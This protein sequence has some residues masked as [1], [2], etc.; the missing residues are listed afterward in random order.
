MFGLTLVVIGGRLIVYQYLLST[1][2]H[3]VAGEII[4]TGTVYRTS[5]GNVD[6]IR[7]RFTDSS[8]VTRSGLSSGYSG[9]VGETV[10]LEYALNF[11]FVHRISGEGNHISYRLRWVICIAGCIFGMAGIHWGVATNRRISRA[12]RLGKNGIAV[13]GRVLQIADGGRTIVYEYAIE[14]CTYQDK[15]FAMPV[16]CVKKF[17]PHDSIEIYVD[18]VAPQK[19]VLK[20]EHDNSLT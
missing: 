17:K 5:G 18:P 11:P 13:V 7:Y 8:G 1:H 19:S 6:Y 9:D 3:K 2:G 15:S 14:S 4:G 12:A 10:L 20:I 16:A